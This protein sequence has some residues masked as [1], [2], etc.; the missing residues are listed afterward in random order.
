M[1]NNL[2][3]KKLLGKR[4]KELRTKKHL[5]QA[6]LA[7]I[8]GMVERNLSKI[9]C[10]QTFVTSENLS[11]IISALDITPADLFNFEHNKEK[12]ELKEELINA[13]KEE[14]I[15]VNILYRMYKSLK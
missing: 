12:D 3:I 14:K 4:I 11:K 9:E 8:V 10:G 7:E 13:I 1:Q 5:T 2:D 6:Q 15:D